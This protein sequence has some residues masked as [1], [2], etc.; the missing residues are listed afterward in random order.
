[1]KYAITVNQESTLKY[2]Y[3]MIT[4]VKL[5]M[6]FGN[7]ALVLTLLGDFSKTLVATETRK[8][9]EKRNKSRQRHALDFE[10]EEQKRNKNS[11]NIPILK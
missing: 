2:Y 5:R 1:M 4:N 9:N 6:C 11:K 7:N 3:V 10:I 8:T